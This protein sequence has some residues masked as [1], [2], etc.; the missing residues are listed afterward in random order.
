[1]SDTQ[2]RASQIITTFGPG[3]MVDFPDASVLVAG[4]DHWSYDPNNFN[5]LAKMTLF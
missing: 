5:Q 4:L 3:A 1:M 2:L